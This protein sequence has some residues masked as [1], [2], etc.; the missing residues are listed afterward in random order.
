MPIDHKDFMHGAALVAI[1]DVDGFTALNKGSDK[2]GHYIVDH[3]RHLFIKYRDDNGPSDY[4]FTFRA[5]DKKMTKRTLPRGRVY[6]VLVC[7]KETITALS[8]DDLAEL[9]DLGSM[10]DE[11]VRV[12]CAGP[13]AA[14]G[15]RTGRRAGPIPRNAFPR[16][17]LG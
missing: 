11:R 13:Q 15:R 16:R 12:S 1:A 4:S 7:G 9:I 14:A 5:D 10:E 17:I 6:V 3:D 2:Y 8:R